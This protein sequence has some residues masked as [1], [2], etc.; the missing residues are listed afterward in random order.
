MKRMIVSLRDKLRL[1]TILLKIGI[2]NSYFNL[3]IIHFV[4]LTS[5]TVAWD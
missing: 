5:K 2:Y 1:N 4:R 3:Q